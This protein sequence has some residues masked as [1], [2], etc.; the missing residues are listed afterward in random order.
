MQHASHNG[1]GFAKLIAFHKR[2][3][4]LNGNQFR[5]PMDRIPCFDNSTSLLSALKFPVSA[6]A[7]A[8]INREFQAY[9]LDMATFKAEGALKKSLFLEK[10]G[11]KNGRVSET[12]SHMTTSTASKSLIYLYKR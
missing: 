3:A 9:E 5:D 11:N 10:Q 2:F 12:G 8:T 1:K 7:F 4:R 6:N